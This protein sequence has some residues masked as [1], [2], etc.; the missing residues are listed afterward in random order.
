MGSALGTGAGV[1]EATDAI[2]C[3]VPRGKDEFYVSL[4]NISISR[5]PYLD[6][7]VRVI[8]IELLQTG[9]LQRVEIWWRNDILPK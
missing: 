2:L 7:G 1:L 6:N 3:V 8:G 5:P 4:T 9:S